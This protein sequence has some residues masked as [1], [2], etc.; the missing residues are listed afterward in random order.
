MNEG[1][2]MNH[3]MVFLIDVDNTLFDNDRVADGFRWY[4]QAIHWRYEDAG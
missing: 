2:L 4:V 3:E 1:S